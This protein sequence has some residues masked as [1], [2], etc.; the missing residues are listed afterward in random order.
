MSF[1]WARK[2]TQHREDSEGEDQGRGWCFGVAPSDVLSRIPPYLCRAHNHYPLPR[3]F[4]CRAHN[5]S[6]LPPPSVL[7]EWEEEEG[8]DTFGGKRGIY[9]IFYFQFFYILFQYQVVILFF[10]LNPYWKYYILVF[11][12]L[13][14]LLCWLIIGQ[15]PILSTVFY[16]NARQLSA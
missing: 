16:Q 13:L 1:K 7:R 15:G 10:F 4:L 12:L 2:L 3:P 9:L 8:R 14:L 5:H 11:L 6:P